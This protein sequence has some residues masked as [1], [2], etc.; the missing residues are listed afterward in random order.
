MSTTEG[1]VVMGRQT[2]LW[3][4]CRALHWLLGTEISYLKFPW[5]ADT[6]VASSLSSRILEGTPD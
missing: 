5:N 2:C 1:S 3:K 4:Q 6:S